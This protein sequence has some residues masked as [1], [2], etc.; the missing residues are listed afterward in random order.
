MLIYHPAFDAYH[1][2]FRMLLLADQV[3]DLEIDKA[4]LLDF[5]I[6]FPGMVKNIRLPDT[7]KNLRAQAKGATNLYRDPVSG[8]STFREMRHIQDAAL[9]C[10]AASGLIDIARYEAG[11]V[12]RTQVPINPALKEK[13]ND[14]LKANPPIIADILVGLSSIPLLGNDGLKHRSQLMEHRY[15]YV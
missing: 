3:L 10:I 4:K 11:Y 15:D 13:Q 9:K 12:T 1:C 14:F 2:V 6:L 8:I 5:Y 7:L